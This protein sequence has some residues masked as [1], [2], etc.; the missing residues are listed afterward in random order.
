MDSENA[1]C[2]FNLWLGVAVTST[3]YKKKKPIHIF[4]DQKLSLRG[5]S[6]MSQVINSTGDVAA[7]GKRSKS[8]GPHLVITD[9]LKPYLC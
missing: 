2:D 4:G 6:H 1:I 9:D 3:V 7:D 8:K 5:Q